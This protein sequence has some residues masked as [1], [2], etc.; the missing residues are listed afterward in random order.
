MK[1]TVVSQQDHSQLHFSVKD[2][3]PK[4]TTVKNRQLKQATFFSHRWKP[5]VNISQYARTNVPLG[6]SN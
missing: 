2:L 1:D 5:A 3:V 4:C 6:F